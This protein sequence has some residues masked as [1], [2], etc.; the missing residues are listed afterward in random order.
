MSY[1]ATF[2]LRNLSGFDSL[3]FVNYYEQGVCLPN[4]ILILVLSFNFPAFLAV[5]SRIATAQDI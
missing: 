2:I 3:Y 4:S 5:P 1:T